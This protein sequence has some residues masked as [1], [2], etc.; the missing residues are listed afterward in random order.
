MEIINQIDKTCH[1]K[2]KEL[3]TVIKPSTVTFREKNK[4]FQRLHD[5]SQTVPCSA[6]NKWLQRWF[7]S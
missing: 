5:L 2:R 7:S 1:A 6:L 4:E 3:R